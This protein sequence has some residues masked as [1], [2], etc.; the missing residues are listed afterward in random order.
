M[1][2]TPSTSFPA[3]STKSWSPP[4]RTRYAPHSRSTHDRAAGSSRPAGPQP[5]DGLR[6]EV[7]GLGEAGAGIAED[8][9]AR[10]D[11][12]RRGLAADQ[13]GTAAGGDRKSVV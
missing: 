1:V 5:G 7:D 4:W 11:G 2:S 13:L 12:E 8:H 6:E 9:R 10:F 3:C